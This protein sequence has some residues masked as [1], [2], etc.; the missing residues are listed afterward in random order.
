MKML[1]RSFFTVPEENLPSRLI[2]LNIF[3]ILHPQFRLDW[4]FDHYDL[5]SLFV[6]RVGNTC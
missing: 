2:T 6:R 1:F 4:A 5:L 3:Y